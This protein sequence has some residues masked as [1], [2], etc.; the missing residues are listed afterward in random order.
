M[1]GWDDDFREPTEDERS[2]RRAVSLTVATIESC[3]V[4]HHAAHIG[5]TRAD[6]SRTERTIVPWG[7]FPFRSTTYLVAPRLLDGALQEA[8]VYN[9][10]RMGSVRELG[11]REYPIPDGFDVRDYIRLPFQ[12]GE[13]LYDADFQVSARR[14]ADVREAVAGSGV[15]QE[16]P[17]GAVVRI[18]VADEEAAVAALE[19]LIQTG[20]K[21]F[22]G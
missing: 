10:D 8:H 13:S 19:Q 2:A 21:E 22:E 17:E 5:Y 14:L 15:W 20:F 4:G 18:S 3:I 6:G 12:L 9:L 16:G 7:L 1:D 11:G